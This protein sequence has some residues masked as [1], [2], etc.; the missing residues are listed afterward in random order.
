MSFVSLAE[1]EAR[2]SPPEDKRHALNGTPVVVDT[3]QDFIAL[4][5]PKREHVLAPVLPAKGLAMLHAAR[6]IGKTH[7][8]MGMAYAVSTGGQYLR[9]RAPTPRKVLYVD[10]E[11]PA[12]ALQ[13]RAHSLI[14]TNPLKPPSSKHFRLLS[15]DRQDLGVS[16]NLAQPEHQALIER[17]IEDAELLVLDNLSTLVNGGRENDAESWNAMQGW[18]LQ[19]RRRGI[20]VLLVHHSGRSENARGTSKRED[21]LDTVIRLSRPDDYDEE[22]GARFE[23]HL[24]KARGV[25]GD[26]ALPFEAQLEVRDGADTWIVKVLRD[27]VLD[28]VLEMTRNRLSVRDIAS[29]LGLNKNKVNRLQGKLRQEG[30][31]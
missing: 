31:L 28:Q 27:A 16:V 9:W 22:Q 30:R 1:H 12:E 17:V 26:D 29:E 5:L 23:V 18:L 10:G 4:P 14:A 3:L 21:I 7:A 24:T 20:S 25:H 2:P 15:M 8:A 11:M 13:A 19:L 6:G